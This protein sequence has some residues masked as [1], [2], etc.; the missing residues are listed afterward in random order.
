MSMST[1]GALTPVVELP[2]LSEIGPR[3]VVRFLPSL[4]ICV[5]AG[6]VL[7]KPDGPLSLHDQLMMTAALYQPA[8]GAV[9]GTP[10]TVGAEASRLMSTLT[11]P[12]EPPSL[13]AE[14]EYVVSA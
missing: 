11:G 3:L 2:A 13:V 5:V 9:A 8:T 14:Q 1:A 4:L 6:Q 12:A 7:T 10:V